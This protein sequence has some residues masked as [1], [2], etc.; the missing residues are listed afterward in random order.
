MSAIQQMIMA[1]YGSA[2]A[3][4]TPAALFAASEQG[5]W[6]DPSDFSTLFQDSA[7]TVPVTTVDQ[8]VGLML[9]KS[10]G[11]VLGSELV[12]NGGFD[13]DITGWTANTGATLSYVD[14]ALQIFGNG[15]VYEAQAYQALSL[16]AGSWY[17]IT[18]T[19]STVDTKLLRV[20]TAAGG[21]QSLSVGLSVGVNTYVF[22]ATTSG[23]FITLLTI[24]GKTQKFDD[25][26]IRLYDGNHAT[27]ATTASKPLYQSPVAR[28]ENDGVDDKLLISA[29]PTSTGRDIFILV[30]RNTSAAGILLSHQTPVIAW[31]GCF[32]GTASSP[33]IASGT[34]TYAVNG[35]DVAGGTATTRSQLNSA[36]PVGAWSVVEI[37]NVNMT[38]YT[39][40]ITF[41]SWYDAGFALNG[42]MGGA[43]MCP[44]QD[45]TKRGQIRRYLGS[46][47]GL[48]L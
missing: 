31:V 27:Q 37:R 4:W 41:C 21:S 40:T 35:V 22:R 36:I 20:G 13:T 42:G 45:A 15:A 6:Y 10:K 3:V 38:V 17:K 26:S 5:V 24:T 14:G 12:T 43:V 11:L 18:V 39:S 23:Q 34:P 32:D 48:S 2:P 30:Y 28:L 9:D 7:G 1:A 19:A 8:P 25:V 46:K 33:S 29:I 16:T 47:A 44:A